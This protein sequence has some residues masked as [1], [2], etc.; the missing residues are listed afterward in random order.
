MPGLIR[1][2]LIT[3][4]LNLISK[5][6]KTKQLVVIIIIT[7]ITTASGWYAYREY[8]RVN[9]DLTFVKASAE[10]SAKD[11]LKS[12]EV[13]EKDANTKYLGKI[14]TVAGQVK[15]IHKDE[16]GHPTIILGEKGSMAS[17]RCSMDSL[18]QQQAATLSAGSLV[19]MK[20]ACTGFNADELLG[21]D[22]IL[23]R[24]VVQAK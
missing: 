22:V 15:E 1:A 18:Y 14:I 19:I 8:N 13:N 20:G 3:D 17:V 2:C 7:I 21:S 12:F 6:M 24:C 10:V 5:T 16:D 4:I 11:I 9:D 23:N